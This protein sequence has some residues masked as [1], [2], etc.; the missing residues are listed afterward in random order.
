MERITNVNGIEIAYET[1]GSPS[2]RPLLLIMGLGGQMIWWDDEFC[3]Q[4]VAAG[5]FVIRFDN[6]DSGR[7]HDIG[8]PPRA[9]RTALRLAKP[10]YT[11]DD[12]AADAAGVLDAAGLES[13]HVVGLSMGSMI[14]QTLALQ[15]RQRVRSLV[16]MLGTTGRLTAGLPQKLLLVAS[17]F[18]PE[19]SSERAAFI[20]QSVTMLRML[21]LSRAPFDE[22]SARR[23]IERTAD[24]GIRPQGTRRQLAAIVV[25]PDRTKALRTLS[26][27]ALVVHGTADRLMGISGGRATAAAIPGARMLEVEGM[28][29]DLPRFAWPEIVES[30]AAVAERGERHPAYRWSTSIRR[31]S[32]GDL[33]SDKSIEGGEK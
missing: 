26:I 8:S 21:A 1:I 12:M 5:F 20:E 22:A 24:R 28:G 33:T 27:P 6:R 10:A 3:E 32:A 14:A 2:D 4:L 30:I 9:I 11:L 25:Q 16:S 17:L 23:V 13:A 29:H 18:R 7:S 19:G 15:R 31:G